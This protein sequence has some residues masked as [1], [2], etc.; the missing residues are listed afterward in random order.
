ME[1]FY[2]EVLN[3]M[4]HAQYDNETTATAVKRL[5]AKITR[6]HHEEQQRLFLN[7]EDYERLDDENPTLYHFIRVRK[8]HE[9]RTIQTLQDRNGITHTT[10]ASILRALKEHMRMKFDVIPANEDNLHQLM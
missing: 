8:R 1:N 10:T 4:I 9:S 3:T 2:Y 7:T 6:L 5:K